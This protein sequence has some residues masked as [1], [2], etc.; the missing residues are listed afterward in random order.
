M[1]TNAKVTISAITILAALAGCGAPISHVIPP[2]GKLTVQ[3]VSATAAP[4][5]GK[6]TF[7]ATGTFTPPVQWVSSDASIAVIDPSAGVAQC[8]AVGGP[9]SITASAASTAGT[10]TASSAFTCQVSP[11]AAVSVEPSALSFECSPGAVTCDCGQPRTVTVTNT[12]D[13]TLSIGSVQL[14][15]TPY[16]VKLSETSACGSSLSAGQSCA[17]TVQANGANHVGSATGILALTDNAGDSP[18][19]VNL[20]GKSSCY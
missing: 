16:Y 8:I 4:P 13:E 6:V 11:A 7:T 3:P 5:G 15:F 20:S 17:I 18:Q 9:I 1:K 19:E 12:G 14:R 2:Q 10:V